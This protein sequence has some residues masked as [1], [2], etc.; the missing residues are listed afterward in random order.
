M[1]VGNENQELTITSQSETLD[2][3]LN[4]PGINTDTLS[5]DDQA[6]LELSSEA[7]SSTPVDPAEKT[8]TAC[9]QAAGGE[10]KAQLVSQHAEHISQSRSSAAERR[11]KHMSKRWR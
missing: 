5:T 6:A 2:G 7:L 9:Y 8:L 1:L 3:R 4:R 10:I 11:R